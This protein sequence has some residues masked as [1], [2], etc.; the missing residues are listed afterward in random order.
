[1]TLNLTLSESSSKQFLLL[2]DKIIVYCPTDPGR[3]AQ[4]GSLSSINT[5]PLVFVM[6][7]LLDLPNELLEMAMKYLLPDDLDNFIDSRKEF[8]TIAGRILPRHNELK[9]RYT[10]VYCGFFCHPLFLLGSILH[11]PDIVWYVKSMFVRSC[12]G[13]DYY[14][15]E[16]EDKIQQIAVECKDGIVK[17]VQACPYLDDIEQKNYIK[18][19][20][21]G[22]EAK[23]AVLLACMFPCLE[24]IRLS[25]NFEDHELVCMIQKI[26]QVN[27]LNPGGS[28]A[29][30]KLDCI[31]EG[32]QLPG[33]FPGTKLLQVLS[34]LPSIRRYIG[35]NLTEEYGWVPTEEKSMITSLKL[36]DC[37]LDIPAFRAAFS[38]IANLRDFTYENSRWGED[39]Y[40]EPW[41]RDWLPGEMIHSLL[42]FAGHSLV[43]LD[44][45]WT[46]HTE[47]QAEEDASRPMRHNRVIGDIKPF[48]GSLRG[49]QVL[50]HIRVQNEAFVEEDTENLA[51]DRTVHRLVDLLPASVVDV[52]LAMPHLSKKESYRLIEGLPELKAER[53]PKLE[54][55]YFETNKP[56]EDMKTEFE[57][58]GIELVL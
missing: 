43:Q 24:C 15:E 23:A 46:C 21:S 51:G 57:S 4:I 58:D 40:V 6:P 32:S 30:S 18:A 29:L 54:K 49:F 5:H 53:V 3:L 37:T 1:M 42:E 2:V 27:R 22:H 9:R 56:D 12:L 41:E 55:I 7:L 26:G 31:W 52:T 13:P 16:E 11:N 17:S 8:R 28:H 36:F 14:E 48:M 19:I 20:L 47:M 39:P 10:R 35:R 45:T 25:D 33:R 50:K 44:L 34:G 38:S